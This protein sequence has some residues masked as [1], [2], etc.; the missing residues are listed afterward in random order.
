MV[1]Y[2]HEY[3]VPI[4]VGNSQEVI[5]CAREL[6]RK[7]GI[8]PHIFSD[9]F[10]FFQR[11]YFNCHKVYPLRNDFLLDSLKSFALESEKY[12]FPVIVK[13]DEFSERFVTECCEIE[14]YFLTVTY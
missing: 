1:W 10:S 6:K 5:N 4:F 14:S 9:S 7:T 8:R 3:L 2:E 12:Y 13:C 11:I